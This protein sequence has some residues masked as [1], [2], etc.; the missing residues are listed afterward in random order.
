M[1]VIRSITKEKILWLHRELWDWL[2]KHPSCDKSEWPGW[3]RDDTI[4]SET[5]HRHSEC[6]LCFYAFEH[7]G[8]C[9][10][11]EQCL[12]DWGPAGFCLKSGSPYNIWSREDL[13][14][15]QDVRDPEL[16]TKYAKIIRDLP[17][18]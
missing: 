17:L 15:V 11:G 7:F 10:E 13:P 1:R 3:D 12:L 18:K 4:I 5:Y 9:A 2:A 16:R 8:G 14:W 6:F